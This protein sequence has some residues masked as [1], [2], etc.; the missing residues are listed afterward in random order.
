MQ[1]ARER[2]R[3]GT[4]V[5]VASSSDALVRHRR[6]TTP[7][8]RRSGQCDAR[9]NEERDGRRTSE[10]RAVLKSYATIGGERTEHHVRIDDVGRRKKARRTQ[11]GH[12][13]LARARERERE[14]ERDSLARTVGASFPDYTHRFQGCIALLCEPGEI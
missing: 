8:I 2:T 7:S 1:N 10:A 4:T 5:G 13:V 9:R 12:R 6:Q 11:S 14:R 3:A